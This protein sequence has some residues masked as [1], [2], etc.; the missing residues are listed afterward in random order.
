MSSKDTT[1]S[2]S[3][4]ITYA[5][6]MKHN[7]YDDAWISIKGQV[8]DITSFIELHP[9]GDVFLGYLGS[10]VT[11]AFSSAHFVHPNI[12]DKLISSD[13]YL[14][15]NKIVKK[16]Q[17]SLADS[18]LGVT[19]RVFYKDMED[20]D[21]FWAEIKSQVRQFLRQH[22]LQTKYSS[23][24]ALWLLFFN[25]VLC[26]VP[27]WYLGVYRGSWI[28]AAVLA[29]HLSCGSANIAHAA[30]HNGFSRNHYLNVV[31]KHF[32]NLGGASWM[33]WQRMH[34]THHECPHTPFDDQTNDTTPLVRFYDYQ[35][36]QWWYQGQWLYFWVVLVFYAPL[37]LVEGSYRVLKWCL[38]TR[39]YGNITA[40]FCIL[41]WVVGQFYLCHPPWQATQLCAVYLAAMAYSVFLIT[42]AVPSEV[43]VHAISA[44]F[45]PRSLPW[46]KAQVITASDWTCHWLL[47]W[48]GLEH[49]IG[50]FN[51][52]I[53]H[54]LFPS[55][56]PDLYPR[57]Q[58]TVKRVC[59]QFG[60]P[61]V[62]TSYAHVLRT[63]QAD[64][65][66]KGSQ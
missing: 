37:K 51:Y 49:H 23:S 58:P 41:A 8:F 27:L 45:A 21:P 39:E 47:S 20:D 54:H 15:A 59:E 50:W 3:E 13:M 62:C 24:E 22:D 28:M 40:H 29:V 65:I 26:Y 17:L 33:D 57:I 53:E 60:V 10:D 34:V 36:P 9:G 12:E 38:P 42:G 31:A 2:K 1:G 44:D 30:T 48:L 63:Q 43:K 6:L 5:E 7:R 19:S 66:E 18:S 35:A 32:F 4:M 61:Y 46:A 11:G 25:Y 64:F 52:H 55:M 16:G 56:R 14:S